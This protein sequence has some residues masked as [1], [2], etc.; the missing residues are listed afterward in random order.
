MSALIELIAKVLG[1]IFGIALERHDTQ[2][3][4]N[5]ATDKIESFRGALAADAAS[6]PVSLPVVA[7]L[8]DQHDRVQQALAAG[9]QLQASVRPSEPV[10]QPV[11]GQRAA[12]ESAPVLPRKPTE[13]LIKR[14][15][16]EELFSPKA[17]WDISQWT[18]GYGCAAPGKDATIT[19]PDAA[20]KLVIRVQQSV[21]EFFVLFKGH[22]HKF[23][24]VRQECFIDML[25]N[26]GLGNKLHGVRS[27][28]NTLAHI[29]DYEK[30]DWSRV[31]YNLSQSKWAKQVG[32]RD[33][34][35]CK[36]IE[37]G[38]YA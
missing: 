12:V 5:V 36:Q 3:K 26:M 6:V 11:Q 16:R 34:L 28:V 18:Y 8:S 1:L 31:A 38:V 2:E 20:S 21:D 17:Y 37:T 9:G 4:E 19:E 23:N 13:A 10:G 35:I 32:D 15:K 25:F 29:T 22:E 30:P 24:E 27:F 33:V 14:L 7:A